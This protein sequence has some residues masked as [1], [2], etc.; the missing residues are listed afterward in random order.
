MSP[1]CLCGYSGPGQGRETVICLLWSHKISIQKTET[2]SVEGNITRRSF[3]KRDKK[4]LILERRYFRFYECTQGKVKHP[5]WPSR[6]TFSDVAK[7]KLWNQGRKTRFAFLRG[8]IQRLSSRKTIKL[9][10]LI[11]WY[12][13][14]QSVASKYKQSFD[15]ANFHNWRLESL[16]TLHAW[17][18]I[19]FL[20]E[21]SFFFCGVGKYSTKWKLKWRKKGGQ[22]LIYFRRFTHFTEYSEVNK[23]SQSFVP[24]KELLKR[25]SVRKLSSL[26]SDA[27]R[28]SR[29]FSS[30]INYDLKQSLSASK[31]RW[32]RD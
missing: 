30:F 4:D 27:G 9:S 29:C 32:A 23:T 6:P 14:N 31:I 5:F 2:E 24:W 28:S 10:Y 18:N 20:W 17:E 19:S 21:I 7:F 16:W 3:E 15:S 1:C 8:W 26:V 25:K 12:E 13:K 22:D 11:W